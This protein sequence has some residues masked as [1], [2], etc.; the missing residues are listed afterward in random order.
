MHADCHKGVEYILQE[1][2]LGGRDFF[3]GGRKGG[4]LRKIIFECRVGQILVEYVM[5]VLYF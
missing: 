1:T 4:I 5:S 3:S 2:F